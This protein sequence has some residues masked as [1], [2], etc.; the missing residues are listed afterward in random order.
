VNGI[1][2]QVELADTILSHGRELENACHKPEEA[3]ASEEPFEVVNREQLIDLQDNDDDLTTIREQVTS[4]S[5]ASQEP[6]GY[7][8]KTGVLMRRWRPLDAQEWRVVNQVVVPKQLRG[9]IL[10]LAHEGPLAGH[11]GINKTQQRILQ[12]FYWPGLR[13]HSVNLAMFVR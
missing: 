11:L 5:E 7:Y 1:K 13:T 12:H 8:H 2:S 3:N 9:E 6:V 10:R 4:E